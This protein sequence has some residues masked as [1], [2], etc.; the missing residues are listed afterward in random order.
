MD[1][2]FKWVK[3]V[4]SHFGGTAQGMVVSWPGLINDLGGIRRQFHHVIDIVPTILEATG[5]PQPDT[6]NGIKQNPMDGVSMAYTWDKASAD[7]ASRRTTQYFEMLGNRAIYQAKQQAN[8]PVELYSVSTQGLPSASVKLHAPI[9]SGIGVLSFSISPDENRVVYVVS[10]QLDALFELFSVPIAGPANA[11]LQINKVIAD[12]GAY[13]FKI[14]PDSTQVIYLSHNRN[15]TFDD[16][17]SVPIA[18]PASAATQINGHPVGVAGS[19]VHRTFQMS[20]DSRR[21]VY[22]AVQETEQINDIYS[23][24]AAGPA[25]RCAAR[26]GS[27]W[28]WRGCRGGGRA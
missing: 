24:P 23:V 27:R 10:P 5:I 17:Y 18:G 15:A 6:I 19:L 16:L 25:G 7:V 8:A 2:P 14:S 11:A 12:S 21:V 4:P 22:W 13:D 20:A 9:T 28:P 3:Q 1:T 26:P